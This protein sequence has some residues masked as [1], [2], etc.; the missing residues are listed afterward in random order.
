MPIEPGTF[1]MG[2]DG[3]RM[4][5]Y[6]RQK[7]FS[8]GLHDMHGNLAEWCLD[9]YGPYEHR[10]P[11][12]DR[13]GMTFCSTDGDY[14]GF[15]LFAAVSYDEGNTWPDRRLLAPPE[16]KVA[17]SWGHLAVTQ[18]RYGRIQLIT[19]KDHDTFNLAGIKALPPAPKK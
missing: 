13:K 5:D 9:W 15:G 17:E 2:Q 12:N 6:L 16:K 3:P 19:S 4:K 11:C 10:T 7:R 1:T 8:G 18:S 14:T